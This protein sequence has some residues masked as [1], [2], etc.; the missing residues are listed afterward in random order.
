MTDNQKIL[1]A[2]LLD[3]GGEYIPDNDDR[4]YIDIS[5]LPDDERK[6]LIL[7]CHQWNGDPEYADMERLNI[8]AAMC[9]YAFS[10]MLVKQTRK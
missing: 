8:D 1:I 2:K 10:D 7:F 6:E 3:K 9:M 4:Q 5:F